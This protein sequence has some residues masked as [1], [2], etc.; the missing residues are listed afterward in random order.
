MS[1]SATAF[2]EIVMF[3]DDSDY[4]MF[5]KLMMKSQNEDY[6]NESRSAFI[7]VVHG[8]KSSLMCSP[9]HSSD[10]SAPEAP[11]YEPLKNLYPFQLDSS[12]LTHHECSSRSETSSILG[13]ITV[14]THTMFLGRPLALA[15]RC[16]SFSYPYFLTPLLLDCGCQFPAY[17][18]IGK[19]V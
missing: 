1:R 9:I 16:Q 7:D 19:A 18:S 6:I 2:N 3:T 15:Y 11:Q 14:S 10:I 5:T 13:N 4:L 12:L 17:P 8:R